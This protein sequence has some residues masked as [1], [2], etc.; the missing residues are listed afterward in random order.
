MLRGLYR[1]R[2]V[3]NKSARVAPVDNIR[4]GRVDL[5]SPIPDGPPRLQLRCARRDFRS[6]NDAG[7]IL[8]M[9]RVAITAGQ[10][11]GKAVLDE[12]VLLFPLAH[13]ILENEI[14][15]LLTTGISVPAYAKA[16]PGPTPLSVKRSP[17]Y[18]RVSADRSVL[19]R[20][21][22]IPRQHF[23][24]ELVQLTVPLQ[25][26]PWRETSCAGSVHAA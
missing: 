8:Y 12:F 2:C 22:S 13:Q 4:A 19:P 18:W 10:R 21:H 15:A 1:D 6:T 16:T 23:Y 7:L 17:A 11:S 9:M 26:D 24:H 20:P 5:P 14:E 3:G 25:Q